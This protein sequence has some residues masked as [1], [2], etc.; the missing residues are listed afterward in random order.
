M[1][2]L[3]EAKVRT[4]RPT[5][6]DQWLNDGDG[7]Y[8]RV[9]KGGSKVWIIRRKEHGK[10]QVITLD[11][12]PELS[13]KRARLR[14]AEH[15][16][17]THVSSATVADLAQKYVDE[18]AIREFR[19]PEQTQGYL[20]RASLPA[21]GH[22]RVRDVSW[23]ELVRLVQRYTKR[24]PRAADSLRSNLKKIFA[25]GV[26]LGLI[27]VNP[28]NDVS[29]RV[30]GYTPAPRDRVLSDDELRLVWAKTN[31]NARL[32]GFL[33]L[34]GLRIGEA[35]NG[36]Q[37]GERWIVPEGISKNGRPY[38]IH[39]TDAALDQLPLPECSA[40]NVQ[41]WTRRWC[42]RHAIDPRFVPHD[43]RRTAATRMADNGVEP[44]IVER[45]LNHTLE[46][47]MRV[48][49]RAEYEKERIEAARVL[50]RALL[51]VVGD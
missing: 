38:W 48:Y 11:G 35:Q 2:K 7:L 47:V 8:L 34:T 45:A 41:A 13:L 31:P 46:G 1:G 40:T 17:K 3:T 23:A 18:V 50:E 16:L 25:Y 14:A 19:R 10:T 6:R 22:R 4:I 49:N 21:I 9:R 42:D 28:M 12:Y 24:G 27:D 44:F 5:D 20:D 30:A 36:Y 15:Q 51:A 26:E 37:D 29:R 33:L 43:C 39:L 32:L